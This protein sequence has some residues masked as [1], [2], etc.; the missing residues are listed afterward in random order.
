M[1][2]ARS[3]PRPARRSL[4]PWDWRNPTA[5]DY[6]SS[7]LLTAESGEKASADRCDCLGKRVCSRSGWTSP[8]VQIELLVPVPKLGYGPGITGVELR[9]W[10]SIQPS[11]VSKRWPRHR[12]V[13]STPTWCLR[14]ILRFRLPVLD[15]RNP[16]Q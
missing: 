13:P 10:V 16:N 14:Q 2:A 4:L 8:R 3:T 7:T 11:L 12:C 5:S 15:R 9:A 1:L 6:R